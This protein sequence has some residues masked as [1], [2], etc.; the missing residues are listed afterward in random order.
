MDPSATDSTDALRPHNDFT[1]WLHL[2][3][4]E[5]QSSPLQDISASSKINSNFEPDIASSTLYASDFHILPENAARNS[6][7]HRSVSPFLRKGLAAVPTARLCYTPSPVFTDRSASQTRF[8]DSQSPLL[9]LASAPFGTTSFSDSQGSYDLSHSPLAALFPFRDFS[10]NFE[11]DISPVLRGSQEHIRFPL[12]PKEDTKTGNSH[13]VN[14]PERLNRPRFVDRLVSMAHTT[15]VNPPV[16]SPTSP[17]LLSP[18][19]ITTPKSYRLLRASRA[20]HEKSTTVKDALPA[21]GPDSVPPVIG[22]SSAAPTFPLPLRT[23]SGAA[24]PPLPPRLMLKV[25]KR[26]RDEIVTPSSEKRQRCS[27]DELA[28]PSP[29]IVQESPNHQ[30]Q[31]LFATRSFP[32]PVEISA[33]FPLFYRRF[34]ASSYFQPADQR[35]AELALIAAMYV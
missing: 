15:T 11:D 1:D 26:R 31:T 28:E 7:L 14:R 5:N 35:C 4:C 33:S 25:P 19:K 12:E 10:G 9:P 22:K 6:P 18:C 17:T 21:S 8:G 29:P 34:P 23:L 24:S 13:P 2:S 20:G 3:P 32:N 16:P 30:G 27:T